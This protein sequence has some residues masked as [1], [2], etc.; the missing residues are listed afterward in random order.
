MDAGGDL[1]Q[2]AYENGQAKFWP[3]QMPL[4]KFRLHPANPAPTVG[5]Q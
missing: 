1:L 3:K 2:E 5:W 4:L